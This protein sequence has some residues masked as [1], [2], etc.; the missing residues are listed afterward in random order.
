MTQLY[1]IR[2]GIAVE[3]GSYPTDAERPLT[4]EGDRKT[5]KVAKQLAKL[6]IR[7][8]ILFS[9]PLVRA[10]QT[11]KI[12]EER[13]L[14]GDLRE[15]STLAPGGDIHQWIDRL[16]S[17]QLPPECDRP[18]IGLVGHQPD[19]GNWAQ[20]LVWGE[21]GDRIVLKKAG[22]LGL[23]LPESGFPIGRSLL[24]WLTPPKFLLPAKTRKWFLRL[25]IPDY[26]LTD[27]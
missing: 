3:R 7:F 11:A 16:A 13:G 19:L 25:Q 8:D 18:C 6:D 24:F 17:L 2:H 12:L 14:A 1:L 20:M 4:P 23:T 5:R 26:S 22:I 21:T 9:S 27:E 10:R 15:T